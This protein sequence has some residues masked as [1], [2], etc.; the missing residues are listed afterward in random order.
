[1]F[2]RTTIVYIPVWGKKKP[3]QPKKTKKWVSFWSYGKYIVLW[4]LIAIY[5]IYTNQSSTLWYTLRQWLR[6][7]ETAQ[8]QLDA[9][10]Q[11][12]SKK[13]QQHRSHVNWIPYKKDTTALIIK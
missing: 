13:E 2:T 5:L 11:Q 1:M 3:P 7:I 10:Q 4:S 6:E 12:V 9:I 8:E